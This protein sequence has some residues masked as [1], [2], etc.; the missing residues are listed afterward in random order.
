MRKLLSR[1][2]V[3]SGGLFLVW[4]LLGGT[5]TQAQVSNGTYTLESSV[6]SSGGGTLSDSTY[7]LDAAIGETVIGRL[8]DSVYELF[9]G[10]LKPTTACSD[11]LD[12]DGDGLVDLADNGC[13]SVDDNNEF[14]SSGGGGGG[15]GGTTTNPATCSVTASPSSILAG[16]S[17][18]IS[19]TGSQLQSF[20]HQLTPFGAVS[21]SGSQIVAPTSTTSYVG[22]FFGISGETVTCS[23]TVSVVTTAGGELNFSPDLYQVSEGVGSVLLSVSRTGG[24]QGLASASI[25]VDASIIAQEGVDYTFSPT[26]LTW[27]DGESGAKTVALTIVD[28]A[29]IEGPESIE[30]AL[31]SVSGATLGSAQ[32]AT[33]QIEDNEADPENPV[34]TII[35]TVNNRGVGT[36]G[37]AS[38]PVSVN[39]NAVT[40]GQTLTLPAYSNMV[41]TSAL[42]ANY[43][44]SSITGSTYC[45]SALGQY[46]SLPADVSMVCRVNFRYVGPM[47]PPSPDDDPDPTDDS[48][49]VDD[50]PDPIDDDPDPVDDDPEPIDDITDPEP[51]GG[52]RPE[53][54]FQAARRWV[55]EEDGEVTV[56]IERTGPADEAVAITFSLLSG[57]A[58]LGADYNELAVDTVSYAA[59]EAGLRA[60]TVSLVGDDIPEADEYFSIAI[61]S[62]S[63]GFV[64]QRSSEITIRDAERCRDLACLFVPE[65]IP[66]EDQIASIGGGL[67]SGVL[68]TA[69]EFAES[70]E[71]KRSVVATAVASLSAGLAASMVFFA[72]NP[73]ALADLAS[74]PARIWGL[75]LSLLGLRRRNQPWGVVYD[76]LTKQP[77]DPAHVI[78]KDQSTG[79][80]V[81]TS[82]TDIDGRYG[83]LVKAGRYVLQAAKTHYAFPSQLLVGRQKDELYDRL[84]FGGPIDVTEDGQVIAHNIPMDPIGQDWNQQAKTKMRITRFYNKH[85]VAIAILTDIVFYAGVAMTALAVLLSPERYNVILLSVYAVIMVLR[86]I[87]LK[88][89]RFGRVMNGKTG[90]PLTHAVLKFISPKTG[91]MVARRMTDGMGRYYA[92]INKGTYTV[93]IELM[94]AD[95]TY[96]PVATYQD[97]ATKQGI[98]RKFFKL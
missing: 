82:I 91:V 73:G 30:F 86:I 31:V 40:S 34:I 23:A 75:L 17:A 64:G 18:T 47:P 36:L 41:L 69:Q 13:S 42:P 89:R 81:A 98:V 12:N 97:I 78:I 25:V 9:I 37:T 15:G 56:Y 1:V 54:G 67:Q 53:V 14:L 87:G 35:K 50:E 65:E 83:F 71:G 48:D 62:V 39:G 57:T 2:L 66:R 20:G 8:S 84:Y 32:T 94:Q 90:E 44:V 51:T 85:S 60:I 63:T 61:N 3:L 21:S 46:V 70:D 43:A 22:T 72:A 76:S 27:L 10:F 11:G 92:L 68:G 28:D 80:E 24:T 29:L 49:P 19:W 38:M 45:P 88:S 16:D 93:T 79:Q 95:G 74:L 52:N 5:S 26:T 6:V 7:T 33:V 96:Q 58:L 4:V 55:Q 59:G 77:L